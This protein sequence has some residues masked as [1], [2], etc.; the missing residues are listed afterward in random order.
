MK[1]KIITTARQPHTALARS[2]GRTG[3]RGLPQ[4]GHAKKKGNHRD[5]PVKT[6]KREG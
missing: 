3:T 2:S 5:C 1:V 4:P 6:I